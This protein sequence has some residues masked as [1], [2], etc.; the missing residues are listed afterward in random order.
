MSN[1]VYPSDPT[2]I[3][4]EE[5]ILV[6]LNIRVHFEPLDTRLPYVLSLEDAIEHFII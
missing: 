1:C 2:D 5:P 4:T 3:S 6:K